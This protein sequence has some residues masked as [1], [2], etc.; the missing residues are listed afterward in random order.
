MENGT[1]GPF[2]EYGLINEEIECASDFF[3]SKNLNSREVKLKDDMFIRHVN[4]LI[5]T[6]LDPSS[7]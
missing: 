7:I 3:N 2:L 6:I 4:L 1:C 5:N